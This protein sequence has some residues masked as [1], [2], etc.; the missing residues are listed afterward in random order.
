MNT[1]TR[2]KKGDTAVVDSSAVSTF[3]RVTNAKV[4]YEIM[5]G[6]R[7]TSKLLYVKEEKQFYVK[8]T[9]SNIG[10][11]YTCYHDGCSRRVHLRGENCFIGDNG[12]HDHSDK[13]EMYVNLCALNEM[14]GILRS[15]D[16]RRTTREVFN[17][18]MTR[19]GF[20]SR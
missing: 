18:V 19:Q 11:G 13:S 2:K 3:V 20:F 15:A 10:I 6:F 4:T 9:K 5:P 8:N 7:Y 17:D 1:I 12:V 14:K 16:K